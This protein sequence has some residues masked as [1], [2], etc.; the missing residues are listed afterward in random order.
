MPAT[1][2]TPTRTSETRRGIQARAGAL[3]GL[4]AEERDAEEDRRRGRRVKRSAPQDV[5]AGL[6]ARGV[7][8][9]A[10]AAQPKA[11]ATIPIGTLM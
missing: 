11:R 1:I 4:L 6:R 9:P 7:S 3:A 8:Q 2:P 10:V 5:D